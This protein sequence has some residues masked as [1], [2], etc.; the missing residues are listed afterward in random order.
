[1]EKEIVFDKYWFTKHQRKLLWLAN[2]MVGKYIFQFEKMGHKLYKDKKIVR[3]TPSSIAHITEYSDNEVKITEQFFA[4]NEYS[5]KLY[6]A[7]K[8]MWY[9]MHAWDWIVADHFRLA[10]K[11]SF[12]FSTLIAVPVAGANDPCD[13]WVGYG[14]TGSFT[15]LRNQ[16]SGTDANVTAG[17]GT[18]IYVSTAGAGTDFTNLYHGYFLFDTSSIPTT[19]TITS[20]TFALYGT[21]KADALGDF[22]LHVGSCSPAANNT[23]ANADY[24]D[25]GRVT[26]GSVTYAAY[27][28][29]GYNTITLNASGLANITKGVGA[30]SKFS[31]QC[32]WD[33]N[34]NFTGV[35]AL[36]SVSSFSCNMADNGSNKPTLTVEYSL[37]IKFLNLL[38]V[39]T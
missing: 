16:A 15:T 6:F 28:T 37:P 36:S 23:L 21:A 5:K 10:P 24:N 25:V 32:N 4:R 22:E 35:F 18:I 20:A 19:N 9:L 7:L 30:R 14:G 17:S 2:S 31:A 33:M 13:G 39:G 11:L 38:G 12:G 8:P 1:M 26:F 34:D 29:V 3:I 27:S